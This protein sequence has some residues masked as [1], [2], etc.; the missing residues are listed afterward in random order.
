MAKAKELLQWLTTSS[1]EKLNS[2][3]LRTSRNYNSAKRSWQLFLKQNGRGND[4]ISN[5]LMRGYALWLGNR[6]VCRNTASF[7]MRIMRAC[8][9]KKECDDSLFFGL[10]MGVD[11]TRKRALSLNE[12]K[13]LKLIELSNEQERFARD[14][15][16]LSFYLRG[17][18]FVDLAHLKCNNCKSGVVVY[19]R[20]KTGQT[21]QVAWESCMGNIVNNWHREDS[22]YM[23]PLLEGCK[24]ESSIRKINRELHQIG[25]RLGFSIPLSSY[26][27]RH[28]WASLAYA[29]QIPINVISEGLGHDSIRTT[30]IYLESLERGLV[31]EANRKLIGMVE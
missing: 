1:E 22:E 4:C 28:T 14:V 23:L 21:I 8:C 10:Y 3:R 27:A 26:V 12:L 19:Q 29:H 13:A 24:Y 18:S 16:L 15:F 30:Q 31:D 25:C 5:E 20:H 17:I 9:R 2:N 7:Y 6:G 11:K